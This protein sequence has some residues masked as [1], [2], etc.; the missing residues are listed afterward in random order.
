MNYSELI[1]DF[2]DGTMEQAEEEEF[3]MVIARRADL[4]EELRQAL[5]LKAAFKA[6]FQALTPPMHL[7]NSIFA[8]MG[9]GAPGAS[10]LGTSAL[11]TV[12]TSTSAS[13]ATGGMFSAIHTLL[14]GSFLTALASS[15]LTAALFLTWNH[16]ASE[17]SG[18]QERSVELPATLALQRIM[19][20]VSS[21]Q[22]TKHSHTVNREQ[23]TASSAH[24]FEQNNIRNFN[25]KEQEHSSVQQRQD[26]SGFGISSSSDS[27]VSTPPSDITVSISPDNTF[28][29]A[30]QT[31]AV[32]EPL[33]P[34]VVP[35]KQYQTISAQEPISLTTTTPDADGFFQ[36]VQINA[37]GITSVSL[38]RATLPSNPPSFL[39]NIAI[40][41]LYRLTE[42]HCFGFEVGEETFFQRFRSTDGEQQLVTDIQQNPSL[43]WAGL[44]YRYVMIPEN[45]VSPIL[46]TV[47]GGTQLG[48]TGRVMLGLNYSPDA[49]T[50]FTLGVESSTLVYTHQGVWYASP[51]IGITYGVSL[52]F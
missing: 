40:G 26:E 50:Q 51:K 28:P 22:E 46:H 19:P 41:T 18:Q 20:P 14:Q 52:K 34:M 48:A 45:N 42:Q 4:R 25:S 5:A 24:D 2:L 10:A 17:E 15:F 11:A 31:S 8:E 12:G 36:H 37:R 13:V 21:L 49:R 29:P 47:L 3:L 23:W 6:D 38:P 9:F 27:A 33:L 43:L 44:A 7:T 35:D 39:R 16:F 30:A 1:H 32:R